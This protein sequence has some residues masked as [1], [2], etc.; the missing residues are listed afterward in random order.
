MSKGSGTTR[1][2]S[3]SAAAASRT[4]NGG[5]SGNVKSFNDAQKVMEAYKNLYNMPKAEQKA[6]T[7]S[8]GQA[9]MDGYGAKKTLYG[10]ELLKKQSEAFAKNDKAMYDQAQKVYNTKMKLLNEER[11]ELEDMYNKFIKVK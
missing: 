1:T 6:F 10:N 11:Q 8:F 4:I 5:I 2:I 3:A 9:M 7:D